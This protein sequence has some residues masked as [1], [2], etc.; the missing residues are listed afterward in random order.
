MKLPRFVWFVI[1]VVIVLIVL[2]VLKV[3]IHIGS[4]GFGITQGLV[5]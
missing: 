2:V 3:N 5:R 4:E 1:W